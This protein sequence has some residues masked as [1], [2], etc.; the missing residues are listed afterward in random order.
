MKV[1]CYISLLQWSW[2]PIYS[3]QYPPQYLN[4]NLCWCNAV[5]TISSLL[6][7]QIYKYLNTNTNTNT[8]ICTNTKS[9][10][11]PNNRTAICANAMQC[12]WS[13]FFVAATTNANTN[14]NTKINRNTYTYTNVYKNA[15]KDIVLNNI[16]AICAKLMQCRWSLLFAAV[17][18]NIQTQICNYKFAK[19]II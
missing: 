9:D 1:F 10:I 15:K 4:S 19:K 2:R 16:T 14:I 7:L 12:C 13:L 6:P 3:A 11:L 5:P 18:T 8:N 17:T